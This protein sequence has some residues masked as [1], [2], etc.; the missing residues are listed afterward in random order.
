MPAR[1]IG[2]LAPARIS[3]PTRLGLLRGIVAYRW[4][5]LAWIA[6]VFAFEVYQRNGRGV[7]D[8][9]VAH[10][11]WGGLFISSWALLTVVLTLVYRYDPDRLLRPV[12][13][14]TE[15]FLGAGLLLAD[16]W[17]YGFDDHAQSLPSVAVLA[18]ILSTA[19]AAGP[20]SAR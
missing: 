12:V 15:L 7:G 5:T 13:V 1:L 19:I 14:L 20:R 3:P 11:V 17:V 9:R 18:G 6:A 10:P 8:D 16:V 2:R 4:L